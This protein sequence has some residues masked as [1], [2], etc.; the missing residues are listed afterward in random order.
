MADEPDNPRLN[1]AI[2]SYIEAVE[3]GE[4]PDPDRF[5]ERHPDLREELRAFFA[6]H[7]EMERFSKPLRDL[8][9]I[10]PTPHPLGKFGRYELLSVLGEGGMGIVYKAFD[11]DLNLNRTV[12]LKMIRVGR[13]ASAEDLK[14]F[15]REANAA[16]AMNHPNIVPIFEAG[17]HEGQPYFTMPL[18]SGQTL[19]LDGR[20]FRSD[21][22]AAARLIAVVARAI[23][24]AHERKIIHRD[25]KP[26]NILIDPEG[27]PHVTDFGLAT[28]V[29]ARKRVKDPDMLIGTLPYMT[30][31]QLSNR[32]QPLTAA[33]DVWSLGAI[34][35]QLLTGRVPFEGKV[36]DDTIDQIR[37]AAPPPMRA[38]NP[39]IPRDLEKICLRCLQKK[40]QDRYG[41]ALDLAKSLERWLE[42]EATR[43]DRYIKE[44]RRTE[45]R[46][47]LLYTS[48][49]DADRVLM[50]LKDWSQAVLEAA[51]EPDLPSL[52][53]RKKPKALQEF[54]E[55]IRRTFDEPERGFCGPDETPPF[56]SWVLFDRSGVMIACTP[57]QALVGQDFSRREW[58]RGALNR[59]GKRGLDAVHVSKVFLSVITRNLC[60]FAITVPVVDGTGPDDPVLGVLGA[61][62]TTDSN[63]GLR[64][65]SDDRRKVVVVGRW[66]PDS[67][68]GYSPEDYLVLVHPAYHR[69]DAAVKIDTPVLRSFSPRPYKGELR[70][71]E[72]GQVG[73]VDEEFRDPM[74]D[75]DVRYEG[76]WWAGLAPVGNTPFVTIVQRRPDPL[77]ERQAG[78][79]VGLMVDLTGAT[80]SVSG[81]YAEGIQAYADWFNA[82]TGIQGRKVRLVRVDYANR[83]H[84][85][86]EI[87][88]RFKTVDRVVAIQGWGTGD[89]LALSEQVGRDQI[90]YFS[91]SYAEQFSDPRRAPYNF[92][93][94]VDY[95]AQLR[96][97][98]RYLRKRWKSRSAPRIAFVVPDDAYGRAPM[99]AGRKEAQ[100][101]GFEIVG[102]EHVA[103]NAIDASRQILALRKRKPDFVWIG[104]TTPSTVVVLKEA[105]RQN[106]RTQFL[107]AN[108]GNDE[109]LLAGEE[110]EG[111][112][113]LQSSVLFGDDVPGMKAIR[114]A[115][116]DEPKITPYVRG[117]V[118]MMVLCEGLRL[119]QERRDLTGPGIRKALETLTNF[120][121]Q[122]LMPPITFTA[123][124]HRPTMTV[125][126]YEYARRKMRLQGTVDVER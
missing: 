31:E 85:A 10:G 73:V 57:H 117:W 76:D 71:P 70:P 104:G 82:Q 15:R 49:A 86:L 12:A 87:Y 122:G 24:H 5:L 96:G 26:G 123:D 55:R 111:V 37:N 120:D 95:S 9:R 64:G 81:P 28:V 47:E 7:L 79:P 17:D 119:A 6:G 53:K 13:L 63:L 106:L 72:P 121:T 46:H 102:E 94:A 110:A 66:D 62:F 74:A 52:L 11:T 97:G 14:R 77:I 108:W 60:K 42:K 116:G 38:H 27:V 80:S 29:E 43:I 65:L 36:Q 19:D 100:D 115:T 32:A 34:L 35:Y 92:F 109:D 3:R 20:D 59:A 103:L 1:D 84:E 90:P 22:S 50:K 45:L 4:S 68:G 58:V 40:P 124:D 126:I 88:P 83:I 114:E 93:V 56:E 44:A 21:A 16:A 54:L 51:D 25:L 91:G 98:L 113:G 75:R 69:G 61:S 39:A 89:S 99:A 78:I 48:G 33:V 67:Y 8:A 23:H 118:S 18:I 125:R 112:L 101:L 2:V 107:V 30:P 41:S 105:R